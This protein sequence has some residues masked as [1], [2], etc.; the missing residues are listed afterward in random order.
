[1]H[2]GKP[3]SEQISFKSIKVL[4]HQSTSPILGYHTLV[5]YRLNTSLQPKSNKVL[6][7]TESWVG[8]GYEANI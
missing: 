4:V 8:P 3:T 7:A 1:M 2:Y 6:Q 5:E